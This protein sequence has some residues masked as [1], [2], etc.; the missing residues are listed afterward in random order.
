MTWTSLVPNR[1]CRTRSNGVRDPQGLRDGDRSTLVVEKPF[2]QLLLLL[3]GERVVAELADNEEEALRTGNE[4]IAE[5]V[6]K[7]GM[8]G[9]WDS[10]RSR[11]VLG[12]NISFP[13]SN[14]VVSSMTL[15]SSSCE[16]A[17][18][19]TSRLLWST[20][21]E[22]ISTAGMFCITSLALILAFALLS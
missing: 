9:D 19:D 15:F 3:S 17:L 11:S 14:L 5:E 6:E 8:V 10:L 20:C 16:R 22:G 13:C 7:E 1:C 18:L 12:S 4:F 2:S 21:S